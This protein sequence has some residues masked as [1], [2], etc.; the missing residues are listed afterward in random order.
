MRYSLIAILSI[1][2]ELL[3]AE[4]IATTSRLDAVKVFPQGALYDRKVALDLPAGVHQIFVSGLPEGLDVTTLQAKS[5]GITVR[6]L[7][8]RTERQILIAPDKTAEQMSAERTLDAA[9][10]AVASLANKRSTVESKIESAKLR[11]QYLKS[12]ADGKLVGGGAKDN[13]TAD[14]LIEIVRAIGTQIANAVEEKTSALNVLAETDRAL[15]EAHDAFLRAKASLDAVTPLRR[16]TGTA[17]IDLVTE[18]AFKGD[19]TL[20]YSSGDARWQP[21]YEVSVQQTGAK[22]QVDMVRLAEV[23]QYSKED[24]SDVAVTLST[25]D[26]GRAAE[27]YL[28]RSDIKYIYEPVIVQRLSKQSLGQA[29]M[30]GLAEP[31]VEAMSAAEPYQ[32]VLRGQT[33]EFELGRVSSLQGD[34]A[35]KLFRLD[36]MQNQVDLEARANIGKNDVAVLYAQLE[37]TTGGTLLPGRAILIRD[38]VQVGEA[39]IP[40]VAN[41]DT[42]DLALGPLNGILLEPRIL[43]VQDGD[44]GIISSYSQKIEKYEVNLRSLLD[45]PIDVIA[46]TALPVSES[47]DL[48]I[49]VNTSPKPT[50]TGIK[51]RRGVV[52]WTVNMKPQ[53]EQK[54]TYGWKMKWPEKQT[55]GQR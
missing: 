42:F 25:S 23:E 4:V 7:E 28:P 55:L 16:Q 31:E 46:Y 19:L 15:Q 37:N 26:L 24:W 10:Q 54:I 30:D 35:T 45:Y 6:A 13:Q 8:F 18:A 50:E 17:V 44:A 1:F 33:L 47:E 43:E 14:Q 11:I 53:S 39:G 52:S 22:A 32:I 5:N 3:S 51:G 41:G 27:V 9:R 36:A 40:E 21:S 2:P 34:G 20:I 12:L 49:T 48:V 29:Q 38:G